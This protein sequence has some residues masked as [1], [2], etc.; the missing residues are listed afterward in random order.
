M[1]ERGR[2]VNLKQASYKPLKIT[3]HA[4]CMPETEVG[5]LEGTIFL[6]VGGYVADKEA[7]AP[8]VNN[9]VFITKHSKDMK[10]T[11]APTW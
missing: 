8:D 1:T 4:R 7:F 6:G 11:E 9:G 10:L 3:G 5:G 2:M